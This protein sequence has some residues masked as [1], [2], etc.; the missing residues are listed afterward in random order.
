MEALNRARA[1]QVSLRQ[2][3]GGLANPSTVSVDSDIVL[4][5][6]HW[7]VSNLSAWFASNNALGSSQ[8][9]VPFSGI[10][11]CPQGTPAI[12]SSDEN[13]SNMT[14]GAV[15]QPSQNSLAA[16]PIQI[17]AAQITNSNFGGSFGKTNGVVG[18]VLALPDN[19]IVPSNWFLRATFTLLQ[20]GSTFTAADI[21]QMSF[22][23]VQEDNC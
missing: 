21:V 20:A 16:R 23:Y 19:L 1:S 12:P 5:G 13:P 22:A 14:T 18:S 2:Y 4:A 8:L 15:L 17:I 11:L 7:I 3:R 9:A 6:K 10:F